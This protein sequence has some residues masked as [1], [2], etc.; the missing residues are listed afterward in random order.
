MKF[1]LLPT[2]EITEDAPTYTYQAKRY[3]INLHNYSQ[4]A[5][6]PCS[7]LQLW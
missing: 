3:T 2:L 6:P 1:T 7:I 5:S 4:A